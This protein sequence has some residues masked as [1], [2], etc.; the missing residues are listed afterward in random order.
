M[1]LGQILSALRDRFAISS[2]NDMQRRMAAL[3]TDT[4]STILIAPT[5]SGKTIAFAIPLL[6]ALDRPA[7]SVQALIIAPSRELV[8]Q[9]AGVIRPLAAGFKTVALYGGHPMADEVNSLSVVPDI[10]VATPGRLADHI[11]RHTIDLSAVATLVIDEYDKQ[12][13]LGFE[14]EMKRI[15]AR[16]RTLHRIILTSATPLAAYPAWMPLGHNPGVI[17]FVAGTAGLR[18]SRPDIVRIESPVRDKLDTLVDTLRAIAPH[19]AIVFVN[20]RESADRL[21][22]RLRKEHIP[23]GLYHGGLEQADR[24]NALE[25]FANG[26]TPVLVATDLGARGLDIDDVDAVIHYHHAPT[27]ENWT[28]RNGRTAR[29]GAPGT[30][31]V[32]TAEG[33]NIPGYVTTD[34]DWYPSAPNVTPDWHENTTLYLNIGKKEKISRG[35]IAGFLIHK[36]GLAPDQV[37]RIALRDHSAL[38]AVPRDKAQSLIATLIPERIKGRRARISI[39]K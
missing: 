22:Q 14:D 25:R 15:V 29:Q 21:W 31:Y 27:A 26:S 35:D 6:M 38:V 19:R 23:A 1:K 24:E 18:A 39:L 8:T 36:G 16:L 37:G 17:S 3:P 2:L 34:R 4:T 11:S 5:G 30:V 9:I 12:L 7:G 20:H 28:H 10:V 32:I 33:E 13:E